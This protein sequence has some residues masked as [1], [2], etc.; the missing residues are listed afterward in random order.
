LTV[1]I[2]YYSQTS[3]INIKNLLKEQQNSQKDGIENTAWAKGKFYPGS[4]KVGYAIRLQD[5]LKFI[6]K[7]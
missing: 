4:R 3:S 1:K 5:P 7:I 6:E 2:F